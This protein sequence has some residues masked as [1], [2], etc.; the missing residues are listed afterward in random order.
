MHGYLWNENGIILVILSLHV[1]G[2]LPSSSAQENIWFG[3]DVGW[4]FPRWLLSAWSSLI[5]ACGDITCFWVCILPEDVHQASDQEN[6]CFGRS[7]LKNYKM[8][9]KRIAIFDGWMWWF[10]LFLVSMLPEAFHQVSAQENI[11]FGRSFW[12]K[13]S[14]IAVKCM[15]IFDV[16]ME[17]F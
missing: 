7:W 16:W 10:R 14:K 8:D 13:N 12:L 9:G 17:W 6:I 15:A 4:R 3:R 1:P 2:S 5:C 11:W